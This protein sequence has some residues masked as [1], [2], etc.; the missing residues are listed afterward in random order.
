MSGINS[1]AVIGTIE[2]AFE[3]V[4]RAMFNEVVEAVFVMVLETVFESEIFE[5][6]VFEANVDTF[7][8]IESIPPAGNDRTPS[9]HNTDDPFEVLDPFITPIA[10]DPFTLSTSPF[11]TPHANVNQDLEDLFD[12]VAKDMFLM[13]VAELQGIL[14]QTDVD[15]NEDIDIEL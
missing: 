6:E 9:S 15:M 10:D 3:S 2:S 7:N 13:N 12:L 8:H 14:K 4:I 1:E 5:S 11:Q